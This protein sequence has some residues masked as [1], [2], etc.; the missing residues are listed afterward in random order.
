M[1]QNKYELAIPVLQHSLKLEAISWDAHW[2]PARA[3]YHQQN[4]DGALT[5]SQQ[6]LNGSHGA[7]PDIQLC[8]RSR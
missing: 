1:D 4:Y 6:A 2:T 8:S 7:A 3:Y 5:E